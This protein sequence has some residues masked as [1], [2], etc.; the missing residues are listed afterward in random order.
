MKK[1]ILCIVGESGTGKSLL[2][3]YVN[4]EFGIPMIESITTRPK[5]HQDEEGHTWY[6]EKEFDEIDPDDMI[7]YTEFGGYRYCCTKS[8]VCNYCTYV[9]DEVGLKMLQ[10]KFGKEY[11]ITTVR[12][13]R[14]LCS[15]I[16]FCGSDRVERDEGMFT[17]KDNEFDYII[18]TDDLQ[19]KLLEMDVVIK[20]F[21]KNARS[22][23]L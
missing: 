11:K 21:K 12:V 2:A 15:R 9:I 19:T 5:R 8:G 6:T 23:N 22:R 17:M 3:D 14:P 7:A 18:S 20:K 4:V 1:R 13:K 10:E 16:K